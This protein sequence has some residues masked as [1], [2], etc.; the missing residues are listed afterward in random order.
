[1]PGTQDVFQLEFFGCGNRDWLIFMDCKDVINIFM[2]TGGQKTK[3]P[4]RLGDWRCSYQVS[5]LHLSGDSP[6]FLFVNN[7][8]LHS[9]LNKNPP[10]VHFTHF[11][12]WPLLVA[13]SQ[14]SIPVLTINLPSYLC[15][16]VYVSIL[17]LY[18]D[19]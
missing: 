14:L 1:M 3:W 5:S 13:I 17:Y 11:P 15:L 19:I 6:L 16:Y 12:F 7:P 8:I 2:G 4:H 9:L 18:L 10:F